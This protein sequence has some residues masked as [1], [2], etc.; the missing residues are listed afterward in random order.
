MNHQRFVFWSPQ[1][2]HSVHKTL[3]RVVPPKRHLKLENVLLQA[4]A[5]ECKALRFVQRAFCNACYIYYVWNIEPVWQS[6]RRRLNE[7]LLYECT[8]FQGNLFTIMT[9]HMGMVTPTNE[10]M[11]NLSPLKYEVKILNSF[12]NN[13]YK[14]A[15]SVNCL[16]NCWLWVLFCFFWSENCPACGRWRRSCGDSKIFCWRN[17][18]WHWEERYYGL[19][20]SE[21]ECW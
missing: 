17:T 2:L 11:P 21:L 7:S 4:I 18:S 10:A 15:N 3:G 12:V 5:L 16:I 6:G 8:N 19:E 13:I 20:D 14:T 9:S 1:R